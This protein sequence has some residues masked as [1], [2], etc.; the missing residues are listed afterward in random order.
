MVELKTRLFCIIFI[1]GIIITLFCQ[2]SPVSGENN[3]IPNMIYADNFSGKSDKGESWKFVK[4]KWEVSGNSLVQSNME[5]W[6]TQCFRTLKQSGAMVYEYSVIL[7][8]GIR[9]G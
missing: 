8:S 6:N 1:S 4:G 9:S 5:E 7:K 2:V 3:E